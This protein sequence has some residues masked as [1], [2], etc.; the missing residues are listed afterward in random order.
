MSFSHDRRG[1]SV[2]V[3]TVILFG[4]LILA[5]ASYQ[6]FAVPAQN[7]A[8]EF[9]HSQDVQ[10]DMQDLRASLLDIRDARADRFQR[11]VRVGIGFR[12]DSRLFAVNPP[13]PEGALTTQDRGPLNIRNAS[14]DPGEANRF[15]NTDPLFDQTHDTRL[16]TYRPN[17]N[18]YRNPPRTTFEHSFLYNR[19]DE[20]D[21]SVTGQRTIDGDDRTL[22]LV[23]YSNDIDR[24]GL[25][26]TIDP[27]T[28]DGP[29]PTVPIGPD[30]GEDTFEIDLPTNSPSTWVNILEE[31]DNVAALDRNANSVTVELNGTWDLQMARI[32][33][34]GRPVAGTPFSNVTAQE[35]RD[36]VDLNR[37]FNVEWEEP[38]PRPVPGVGEETVTVSITDRE[39]NTPIEDTSVDVS[40]GAISGAKPA[41][42]SV[43]DDG[44]D[45][46]EYDV[47]FDVSENE[48]GDEFDLYASAGDDVDRLRVEIV[49]ETGGTMASR[50]DITSAETT[51]EAGSI[52]DFTVDTFGAED[53]IIT[54]LG[55]DYAA[56]TDG[57]AD[58]VNNGGE[59]EL[60]FDGNGFFDAGGGN[61]VIEL[62]DPPVDFDTDGDDGAN[63]LVTG[64]DATTGTLTQFREGGPGQSGRQNRHAG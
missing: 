24:Q 38:N 63:E 51:N 22:L 36:D 14:V 35:E 47:T 41:D 9:E 44:T 59:R 8:A 49:D 40:I 1:Q 48:D 31:E 37:T 54:G 15:E 52:V 16:L 34:D 25:S 33:Y 53:V 12:Y 23:A 55:I 27:E 46:G 32:G 10:S 6:A 3:G 19:F 4:F 43:S 13:P 18:E 21:R 39:I 17:Y 5:L 26:T 2:V 7:N 58:I 20:V 61:G 62:G 11:P 45:P 56:G 50:S 42:P 64:G 28:I 60:D 57:D 29:T 30:E